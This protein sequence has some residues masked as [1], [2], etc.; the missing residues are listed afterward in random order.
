MKKIILV[1]GY[2]KLKNISKLRSYFPGE[3]VI[4]ACAYT[5]KPSTP[6]KEKHASKFDVLYDLTKEAD[7]ARLIHDS[8]DIACVTCTQERDMMVYI[9][10]QRLCNIITDQQVK[11]YT[12]VIDKYSFKDEMK[13]VH[14]ELIPETHLV[15]DELLQRLD[16]LTYPLV[17]KPTGLAG[18]TM[19]HVV[20]S[21]EEFTEHYEAFSGKMREI[22]NEHYLKNIEIIA[23]S[24][25]TGPQYSVNTYIDAQGVATF[26]PLVRV[27]TPQELGFN[28]TYSVM[29]Y[30]TSEV[31]DEQ[32]D[33]LENAVKKVIAHFDLKNTS[34]HFDS[35]YHNGQWKFFEVGLRIGGNRQKLFEYSHSMDHFGN[36]I[37]NRVGDVIKI[38]EINKSVCVMQKAATH[39]GTLQAIS[40]Q[41]N[42]H[43]EKPPLVIEDKMAKIGTEVGPLS[44]GGGTITRHY[45]VGTNHEEVLNTSKSL[46]DSIK[47]EIT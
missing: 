3:E 35:V 21:S 34:A 11:K 43:S 26:C 22:A 1:A 28:D 42:V 44:Q 25:I 12:S 5:R 2:T 37:K 39:H 9:Q 46:F 7:I 13:H 4:L 29:Q 20:R 45:I 19:I 27:V 38:P 17:I 24:Y 15:N 40:Y 18:S 47:F 14:P 6:S 33:A 31:T 36:D 41:R 32:R 23:E 10:A 8:T 16:T 30:T